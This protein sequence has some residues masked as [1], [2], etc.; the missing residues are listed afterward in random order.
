MSPRSRTHGA[1][2]AGADVM[3]F[4][5]RS[6]SPAPQGRKGSALNATPRLVRLRAVALLGVLAALVALNAPVLS[7]GVG[8]PAGPRA[9][10]VRGQNAAAREV[11]V[12]LRRALPPGGMAQVDLQV[13][14]DANEAVNSLGVRRF[15]SR[16]FDVETLVSFF[17]SLPEVEYAEPNY[18]VSTTTTLND[19]QFPSLWGLFNSTMPGADIGAAQAWDVSTG[20]ANQVVGIIDTGIDYTHPDLAANVWSAPA[21]FTVV[22]GG[23]SITCAA[24]THGFN[25][26]TS[27]CDPRDD[28]NHGTH[29][30]G[31]VGAIGNNALGVVG[32]NWNV[33]LMG[34][35]FLG[36]TGSG[37]TSDAIKAMEFAIQAR[38]IF[39]GS[40]AANVRVLSNS[41]GGGGF[42]QALLDEI[43]KA[44]T[45]D[46][47]F[48]AAAGNSNANNDPTPFY[49]SSFT[50]PNV[51]S[52]AATTSTD[53]KA[54]FSSYGATSVD[55]G[56]PGSGIVSTVRGGGYASYSGTSMA[57][58]HVSGAAALVL[59]VC[60]MGTAALK[61]LIL[62][63]VDVIPALVGI[64]VTEGRLNVNTAV[65]SCVGSPEPD[66]APPAPP[67]SLTA[68]AGNAQVALGWSAS[69]GASS[70]AVKRRVLGGSVFQ[71]IAAA[72][73]TT[74][75]TN[76][77]LTNGV[78]Y[79]YVATASNGLE[80]AP[81][82]VA[83]AT[84]TLP[85]APGVP[86]GLT[87]RA[88]GK[89]R[90]DLSWN[91]PSGAVSYTLK[92]SRTNGG[93]AGGY[94]TI[95]TLT[96]RTFSDRSVESGR[97]YYYVVSAANAGGVSGNSKQASATAK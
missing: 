35:K 8:R 48:V 24:G 18:V 28:N 58:P 82:N 3:K 71:T 50:A 57:T 64:T 77:G 46:M 40:G 80:S 33:R 27:T 93:G 90:I 86:T 59:S 96:G 53:A 97:T 39:A 45:H 88:N 56:A 22:I 6:D 75:Y 10:R 19:P 13:D 51:V 17:L 20:S 83:S 44:N 12:K 43:N 81:S 30:A 11:L 23:V 16:R 74:S 92:R 31:T 95:A 89:R 70:Y 42:S 25:A 7:Q 36:A 79:E 21:P 62:D 1:G 91:A 60:P 65:R 14:A 69:S 4:I 37:S 54:S 47:L 5:D 94:T 34:L 84:P 52:V 78:T 73:A 38:Q 41:W 68:A 72:V 32:V 66:P 2:I 87:A 29:V 76:T 67:A 63:T 55:L 9:E 15:R 61:A 49:P 26:R 85:P